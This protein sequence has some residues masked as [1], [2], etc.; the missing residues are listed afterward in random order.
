VSEIGSGY[1]RAMVLPGEAD[2]P[3]WLPD[4]QV[5][6]DANVSGLMAKHGMSSYEELHAWSVAQPDEFW[7]SVIDDVGISFANS[8]AAMRGS[9]DPRVPDWLPGAR[10]NIV[11]SCL[12]GAPESAAIVFDRDGSIGT[13]T[14]GDLTSRVAEF[15]AGYDAAGYLPGDAVAIIMPMT[16]EA[17]VAYLGTIAAGGVV[18]SI[19]DSFAPDEISARL[20]I[21]DAVAVVT[22]D[23]STRLGKILPMYAKCVE[24]QAPSCIVVG[25]AA[26]RDGDVAWGDFVVPDATFEPVMRSSSDVTNILFSS[27]TTGDPK[28]IPWTHTTPIKAA[29]DGRYHQDIHE[30]DVVAWPTNLGWMMGPWLIYASLLNGAA[31]ALYDDAPTTRG[32]VTFAEDASVT[33]VGVVPSIVSAWRAGGL[34][35]AG[36]W[37]TV[38]VVSST[39][40]ASNASDYA[41]LTNA[42]GSVPIIEYCGGTEI[43]GGYVT[44]TVLH[45]SYPSRFTTPALGVD[46]HLVGEDGLEGDVGEVFLSV[47]SIGFSTTL[48]NRDHTEVYYKDVP[49]IGVPIRRHGDQMARNEDGL[50]RALGRVD[51]TMN[52]GGIKVSSAE[53]EDAMESVAGVAEV[54]AVAVSVDGGGPEEL[55]VFVVTE[56]P[57]GDHDVLR[58]ELQVAIRSHLNPLFRIADVVCVDALPRTASHKVMRRVLRSEYVT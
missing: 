50:Y 31:M 14:V 35:A 24:A 11:A 9:T 55:V 29:M 27:G 20:T 3:V 54:A 1:A 58:K 2:V 25:D 8:P 39:G 56:G 33:M 30:G 51:D 36:D 17:V 44:S 32:F 21:A 45:P 26:F 49:D 28:A 41:W 57:G 42:A 12:A 16:A 34:L 6:A 43:G 10:L 5:A 4:E 40:E 37:S 53:L 19:A 15:A 38:K 23:V 13:I 52:L 46:V 48:L 47:P 18:V 22:Q 7:T